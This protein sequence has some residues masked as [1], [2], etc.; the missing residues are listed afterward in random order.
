MIATVEFTLHQLHYARAR[1][2]LTGADAIAK[3]SASL[4]HALRRA[5]IWNM[6]VTHV[7]ASNGVFT[8]WTVTCVVPAGE[9]PLPGAEVLDAIS[10][11]TS[12]SSGNLPGTR[13]SL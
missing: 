7:G 9:E 6:V 1:A 3:L 4:H 12:T 13:S 11:R 5:H 8:P 2:L 10:Y